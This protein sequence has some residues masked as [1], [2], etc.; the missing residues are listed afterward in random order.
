[1]AKAKEYSV[2]FI[3]ASKL[4]SSFPAAFRNA[5]RQLAALKKAGKNTGEAFDNLSKKAKNFT[6]AIKWVGAAAVGAAGSLFGIA[7]SAATSAIELG[8]TAERLKMPAEQLQAWQYAAKQAGTE[9]DKFNHYIQKLNSTVAQA[10]TAK[11]DPFA[12]WNVSAKKMMKLPIE[13]QL[14]AIAD[15]TKHLKPAEATEFFKTLFGEEGGARMQAMFAKG[16]AGVEDVLAEYKKMGLGFTNEQIEQAAKYNKAWNNLKDTIVNLKNKIGSK[17]W[18][19]LTK[20]FERLTKYIETHMPDVE[21][22]FDDIAKKLG[23]INFEKIIEDVAAFGKRIKEMLPEIEKWGTILKWALGIMLG[24]KAGAVIYAGINAIIATGTLIVEGYKTAKALLS[25]QNIKEIAETAYL[26]GLYLAESA[27]KGIATVKT[28]A[29]AAATKVAAAGQWLL[30]AAMNAN[31]IMLVVTGLALLAGG[32]ILAYNKCEWFR[33]KV[34]AAVAAIKDFFNGLAEKIPVYFSEAWENVKA[35][36]DAFVASIKAKFAPF[37][38][39]ID[40]IKNKIASIFGGKKTLDVGVNMAGNVAAAMPGHAAGGIFNTPHIAKFAENAPRIPEAAIPI[41]GSERSRGLW[42]R[43]GDMSGFGGGGVKPMV[44]PIMS[45]G[46][47]SVSMTVPMTFHINGNADADTVKQ[48]KQ[49]STEITREFKK[50]VMSVIKEQA[51]REK[52]LSY[53]V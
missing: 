12:K 7:H 44:A 43:V 14:L 2:A 37:L 17:F 51:R 8:Q 22:L 24:F 50:A 10:A 23:N 5:E 32:F 11:K 6:K 21:K 39:T 38:E 40:N 16:S 13:K 36:A 31:P 33:E 52:S 26:K 1:M 49:Q 9:S 53:S 28:Y 35:S 20:Q 29:L 45:G 42:E 27:A 15:A 34:D 47:T 46:G 19:F 30:N 25:V 3:I 48:F 4:A 41:D 18:E